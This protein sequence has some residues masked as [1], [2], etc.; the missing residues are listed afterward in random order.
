MGLGETIWRWDERRRERAL[1]R[2][3]I[4]SISEVSDEEAIGDVDMQ[5][6]Q[7]ISAE[8][9]SVPISNGDVAQDSAL[10]GLLPLEEVAVIMAALGTLELEES[11]SELLERNRKAL[12]RLEQLQKM[13]LGAEGGGSSDVEEGSEEWDTGEY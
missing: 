3:K 5:D 2:Y 9:T 8:D 4:G 13:R 6:V 7:E 12:L 11:V 1:Q 10:D